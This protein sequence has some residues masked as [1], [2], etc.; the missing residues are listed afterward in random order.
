MDDVAAGRVVD[1]ATRSSIIGRLL[2]G[3][4]ETET[5][6]ELEAT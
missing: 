1:G 6:T 4:A 3:V 5:G 2:D